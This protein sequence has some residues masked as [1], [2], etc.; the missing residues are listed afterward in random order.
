MAYIVEKK[1]TW[2]KGTGD[3]RGLYGVKQVNYK[4]S[5]NICL[6]CKGTGQEKLEYEKLCK[7]CG[8][9]CN[10][11]CCKSCYDAFEDEKDLSD[12]E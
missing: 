10:G 6:H 7:Y 1:C 9:P 2:C 5:D 8:E 11:Y 12:Y 3:W 4:S